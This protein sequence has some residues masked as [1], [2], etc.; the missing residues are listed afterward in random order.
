MSELGPSGWFPDP[1]G[2]FELRYFNGQRWTGDVS[3]GGRQLVDAE[4][5]GA[6]IPPEQRPRPP[7]RSRGV[8]IAAF[9]T[10]VCAA[11]TGWMPLVFGASAIAAVVGF[12]LGIV[13]L[14][15][16]RAQDGYGR[17]LAAWA[18]AL[19]VAAVPICVAGFF[20]T[21][22]VVE[23]VNRYDDP[24]Q[25]ALTHDE[26][27]LTSGTAV[28]AGTITNQE[29]DTRSYEMTV[30]F[31]TGLIELSHRY[32]DVDDVGPG[33]TVSWRTSD[34]VQTSATSISCD[35]IAVH[36]PPPFGVRPNE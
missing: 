26:C 1:Y 28:F 17:D 22:Y 27:S 36:G 19:S 3:A 30:T 23:Q 16:A 10:A 11:T 8:A 31:S 21:R 13:G 5:T 7:M 35:V 32:V 25:Y 33:E 4:G 6:W 20:F 14:R 2:R 15:R 18:V 9:V 12:V 29:R 24:G 34:T